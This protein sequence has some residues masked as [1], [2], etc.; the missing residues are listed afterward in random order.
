MKMKNPIPENT[1][2]RIATSDFDSF[3]WI[4]GVASFEGDV[5]VVVGLPLI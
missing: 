5:G 3:E 1:I 2:A 4:G